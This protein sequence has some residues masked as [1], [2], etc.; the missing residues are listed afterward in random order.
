MR[1]KPKKDQEESGIAK[2]TEHR[3]VARPQTLVHLVP[4]KLAAPT[5]QC[6]PARTTPIAVEPWIFLRSPA[7]GYFPPSQAVAPLSPAL[8]AFKNGDRTQ[9]LARAGFFLPPSKNLVV[10]FPALFQHTANRAQSP[11][12]VFRARMDLRQPSSA[13]PKL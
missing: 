9:P 10:L 4:E 2:N 12:P 3:A 8:G 6:N 11:P 1:D 5:R 7:A 13:S